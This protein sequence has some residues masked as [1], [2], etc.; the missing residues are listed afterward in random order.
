M[1]GPQLAKPLSNPLASFGAFD[2]NC[3]RASF[4]SGL[5]AW[6]SAANDTATD[7]WRA[8]VGIEIGQ[9]SRSH[10]RPCEGAV[11]LN[12]FTSLP[13]RFQQAGKIEKWL[14]GRLR[15]GPAHTL[16]RDFRPGRG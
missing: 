12:T 11:L 16:A 1:S 2:S 15:P 14:I 8:P 4:C 7:H 6:L 10:R 13:G 3:S 9:G 5:P